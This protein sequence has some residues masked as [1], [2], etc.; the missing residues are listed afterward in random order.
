M[1]DMA[2]TPEGMNMNVSLD[3]E[4]QRPVLKT[5]LGLSKC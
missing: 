5:S 4:Q 2:V 3:I 1:A